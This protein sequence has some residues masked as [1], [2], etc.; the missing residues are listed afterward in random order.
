MHYKSLMGISLVPDPTYQRGSGDIRLIP[1]AS[2]TL[3][4]F[5]REISLHQS[6]SS[7]LCIQQA[8]NFYW[9]PRNQLDVTRSSSRGWGLGTRLDGNLTRLS[10]PQ[11][12]SGLE[13]SC[14]ASHDIL[15]SL[16]IRLSFLIL[17]RVMRP[18]EI[19]G[20]LFELAYSNYW[21][22]H[23]QLHDGHMT[24]PAPRNVV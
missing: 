14:K 6:H 22:Y 13:T 20:Q 12:E 5:W 4:T 1:Q 11:W 10:P 9:S 23:R 8:L 3:I 24:S 7:Q 17:S 2:L 18:E 16:F 15:P 19:G 21:G